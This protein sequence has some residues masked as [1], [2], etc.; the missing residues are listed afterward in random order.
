MPSLVPGIQVFDGH[1]KVL[2][3]R[4]YGFFGRDPKVSGGDHKAVDGGDKP[5]RDAQGF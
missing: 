4:P 1:H 5:G 3:R 2:W